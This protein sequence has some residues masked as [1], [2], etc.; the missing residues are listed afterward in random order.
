M[1]RQRL[2]TVAEPLSGVNLAWMNAPQAAPDSSR[3]GLLQGLVG[4]LLSLLL[5]WGIGLFLWGSLSS[6]AQ[7]GELHEDILLL[8]GQT[9]ATRN[10]LHEVMDPVTKLATDRRTEMGTTLPNGVMSP[11]IRRVLYEFAYFQLQN[12]VYAVDLFDNTLNQPAGASP[13]P[14]AVLH[15]LRELAPTDSTM[16]GDGELSGMLYLIHRVNAPMPHQV[17]VIVPTPLAQAAINRPSPVLEQGRKLGLAIPHTKGWA[18][19][20]EDSNGFGFSPELS[21]AL[22]TA[23]EVAEGD[24]D[25][26]VLLG[27]EDPDHISVGLVHAKSMVGKALVPQII[28]A[29]WIAGMTALLLMPRNSALRTFIT[30]TLGPVT[31]NAGRT[32]ERAAG[33]LLKNLAAWHDTM[34]EKALA[35][36]ETDPPLVDGPGAFSPSDFAIGDRRDRRAGG[37]TPGRKNGKPVPPKPTPSGTYGGH[38]LETALSAAHGKPAQS[39]AVPDGRPSA[40]STIPD[41][42]QQPDVE[43][44]APVPPSP[45]E[46]AGNIDEPLPAEDMEA[47]VRQCLQENRLVLLY[48][49]I[50][51]ASDGKP[52]IHEVYARLVH[53]NGRVISP[54]E[55]LPVTNRLGLT[56]DLDAAVFRK[57][58]STYFFT[59]IYPA[60]PLALNI[61]GNSLDSIG[62]LQELLSHGPHVLQRMAFEVRSQEI[63]RDPKA[64]RLLKDIQRNGG[65]LAVDYF[66]GGTAM[67]QASKAMG[68][69]YIKLDA[70][71]FMNSPEGQDELAGMC[72][73]AKQ[74][75]IPVILEK[76]ETPKEE[77]FAREVGVSYLQGY[78]LAVPSTELTT[79]PLPRKGVAQP[80]QP[81]NAAAPAQPTPP[82]TPAQ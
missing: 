47:I 59:A 25:M 57:T 76:I 79:T 2:R 69:N 5:I 78:G 35:P 67:L 29:L 52:V 34:R 73:T 51:R 75:G 15:R 46:L 82:S 40:S 13:L 39:Q 22:S 4:R 16:I 19:W 64:L 14:P 11:P 77:A 72:S 12:D 50:Y 32:L 23:N 65:S 37:A 8:Q 80:S 68:F 63:V 60:T 71:R 81:G 36:M 9:A 48:Q 7:H 43:A 61:G 28:L 27:L 21:G 74:L 44:I 17:Y 70:S 18:W 66:G 62:Y 38:N 33:P 30:K 58:L 55:F 26:T 6:W 56:Q 42:L 45:E 3:S 1:A 49:P 31:V 24:K 41:V 54:G 10:W 20:D 53:P